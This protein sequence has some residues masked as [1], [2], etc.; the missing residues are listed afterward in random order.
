MDN[1]Q[2]FLNNLKKR[3]FPRNVDMY[4]DMDKKRKLKKYLSNNDFL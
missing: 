3:S 1:K 2:F 4:G